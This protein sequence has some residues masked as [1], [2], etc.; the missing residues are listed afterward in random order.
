MISMP[1]MIVPFES[2]SPKH[3]NN[4]TYR[5]LE[6]TDE[7]LYQTL[8]ENG[9]EVLYGDREETPGVK[10]KDADLT[11]IPT[12][13]LCYPL[14]YY[15]TI[16]VAPH[17]LTGDFNYFF[18]YYYDSSEAPRPQGGASR[19]RAETTHSGVQARI[20]ETFQ[21]RRKMRLPDKNVRRIGCGNCCI[22]PRPCLPAGRHRAGHSAG[23]S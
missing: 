8:S 21:S 9:I 17:Y 14:G 12:L 3:K 1:T 10:F 5:G 11:R 2:L 4:T 13:P 22:H 6:A 16:S 18:V 7:Q 15:V 20:A 23:L 19:L